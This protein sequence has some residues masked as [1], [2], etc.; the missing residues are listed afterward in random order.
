MPTYIC[1]TNYYFYHL[2]VIAP[3]FV[4]TIS[5]FIVG[6]FYP[7]CFTCL[8]NGSP[9]NALLSLSVL[10]PIY[11]E[12]DHQELGGLKNKTLALL[13]YLAVGIQV[14]ASP[15]RAGEFVLAERDTTRGFQ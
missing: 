10:G 14:H 15:R 12:K 6:L 11:V 3:L 9:S 8:I 5:F 13:V 7:L 1:E 2:I 4:D